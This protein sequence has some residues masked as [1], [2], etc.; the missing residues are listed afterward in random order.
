MYRLI[1]VFAG[2]TGL[3]VG[4]VM[5]WLIYQFIKPFLDN[6]MYIH[7]ECGAFMGKSVISFQKGLGVQESKHEVVKVVAFEKLSN[8]SNIFSLNLYFH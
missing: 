2:L 1:W 7:E 5:R 8:I 6:K 3:I 4:F